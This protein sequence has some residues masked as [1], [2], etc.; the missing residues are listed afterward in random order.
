M[1][2]VAIALTGDDASGVLAAK[3]PLAGQLACMISRK[4]DLEMVLQGLPR[5]SPLEIEKIVTRHKLVARIARVGIW[6]QLL[7]Q[8]IK[9]LAEDNSPVTEQEYHVWCVK[10]FTDTLAQSD[11]VENHL[12]SEIKRAGKQ[13]DELINAERDA[14]VSAN[15]SVGAVAAWISH[16]GI[17][18]ILEDIYQSSRHELESVDRY[19]QHTLEQVKAER[20]DMHE[21][22]WWHEA[23]LAALNAPAATSEP[24]AAEPAAAVADPM[25]SA[26][27]QA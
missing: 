24:A 19:L 4:A 16:R 5:I 11:A 18:P 13:W 8:K 15:K 2:A 25:E 27:A 12:E 17:N 23:A 10:H 9:R 20:K 6:A 14:C 7:E 3:L 1:E 22:L 21:R 26:Q